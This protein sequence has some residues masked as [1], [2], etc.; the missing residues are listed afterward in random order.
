MFKFT[1]EKKLKYIKDHEEGLKNPRS[2]IISYGIAFGILMYVAMLLGFA[3]FPDDQAQLSGFWSYIK[4]LVIYI[5]LGQL[6]GVTMFFL[7]GYYVKK[8]KRELGQK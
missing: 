2:F 5:L 8:Y 7:T 6:Y 4:L 3:V 1:R